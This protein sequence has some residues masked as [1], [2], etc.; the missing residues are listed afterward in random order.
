MGIEWGDNWWDHCG[1][2]WGRYSHICFLH[3]SSSRY[4][5]RKLVDIWGSFQICK[6]QHFGNTK[7]LLSHWRK[8]GCPG[9]A[10][11]STN[12]KHTHRHI[13]T[14]SVETW[15]V[16][17]V[18]GNTASF[19]T[20]WNPQVVYIILSLVQVL[21]RF[22]KVFLTFQGLV[23]VLHFPAKPTRT[24][25]LSHKMIRTSYFWIWDEIL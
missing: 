8:D 21:I 11:S 4:K 1:H 19:P 2:L 16:K 18:K 12:L 23:G 10:A 24:N 7:P 14:K 20:L 13:H 25:T 3:L 6:I 5:K 22:L 17:D 9:L 15:P